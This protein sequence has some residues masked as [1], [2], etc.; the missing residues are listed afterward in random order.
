MKNVKIVAEEVGKVIVY[1]LKDIKTNSVFFKI[2]ADNEN[3]E[4]VSYIIEDTLSDF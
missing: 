3:V 4:Q 1:V 2:N